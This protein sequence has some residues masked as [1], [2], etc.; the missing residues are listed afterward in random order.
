M[1]VYGGQPDSFFPLTFYPL[2]FLDMLGAR[3]RGADGWLYRN[4]KWS[5][6]RFLD[7]TELFALVAQR[8]YESLLEAVYLMSCMLPRRLSFSLTAELIALE[9]CQ[10]G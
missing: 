7:H 3:R 2:A 6:L 10:R 4:V 9:D 5:V 8:L 1:L